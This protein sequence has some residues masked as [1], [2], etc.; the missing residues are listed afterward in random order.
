MAWTIENLMSELQIRSC[1]VYWQSLFPQVEQEYERE[2]CFLTSDAYL[3]EVCDG[4]NL[5]PK[6][7]TQVLAAARAARA[8]PALERWILLLYRAMRDRDRFKASFDRIELP[9]APEGT[10]PAG[11]RHAALFSILGTVPET[12]SRLRSIGV[13]EQVIEDTFKNYQFCLDISEERTGVSCFDK[14]RLSWSQHYVD[15]DIL[16]LGRLEFEMLPSFPGAVRLFRH[17]DGRQVLL[18]DGARLHHSGQLLGNPNAMDADGAFDACFTEDALH[19]EGYPVGAD[20]LARPV[21]LRLCKAEWE[22]VLRPGDPVLNVHIPDHEP[23]DPARCEAAYA[24]ARALFPRCFPDFAFRSFVCFSWLM[25]PQL[26]GFLKPSS[27]IRRFRESYLAFPAVSDGQGAIVFLFVAPGC[28]PERLPEKSSLQRA[29]K[30]HYME[31]KV[32]YEAGGIL[33]AGR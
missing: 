5:F 33:A 23:F 27:N 26:D 8:L 17:K 18:M 24:Q 12:A 2:G 10:D 15:G 29:L 19:A 13:P 7:L 28:P 31:G 30:R 11:Y 32:I 9:V 21:R 22:Q 25:D 3:R 20:G 4:Y 1:P 14:S 16:R 6:R